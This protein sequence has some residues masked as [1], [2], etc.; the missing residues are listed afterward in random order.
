MS[1]KLYNNFAYF[2]EINENAFGYPNDSDLLQNKCSQN[3]NMNIPSIYR[4]I[5][6]INK[7]KVTEMFDSQLTTLLDQIS[8]D[9]IKQ[10]GTSDKIIALPP[11]KSINE[12]SFEQPLDLSKQMIDFKQTLDL[13]EQIIG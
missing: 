5:Y 6:S 8:I 3:N 4:S 10:Q 7:N 13:S 9:S 1:N 11:I 12:L 2:S